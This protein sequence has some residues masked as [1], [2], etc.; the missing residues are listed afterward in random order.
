MGVALQRLEASTGVSV[1]QTDGLIFTAAGDRLPVRA[2]GCRPDAISMALQD[3]EAAA[4]AHIPQANG[5][6]V[7][8]AGKLTPIG[9]K[10]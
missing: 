5:L 3:V 7:T 6:I 10:C 4:A 1:P 8:R 9:M 2:E